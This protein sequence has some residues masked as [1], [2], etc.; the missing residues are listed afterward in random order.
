MPGIHSAGA[1][2]SD[3]TTRSV[4]ERWRNTLHPPKRERDGLKI[5]SA[6][7]KWQWEEELALT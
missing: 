5:M 1:K 4:M 3:T 6:V 7:K 2:L